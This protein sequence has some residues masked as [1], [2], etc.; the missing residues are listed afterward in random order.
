MK[1]FITLFFCASIMFAQESEKGLFAE[2]GKM[3]AKIAFSP[4]NYVKATMTHYILTLPSNT[5]SMVNGMKW[6]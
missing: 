6:K 1:Q 5:K 3:E 4:K 2:M